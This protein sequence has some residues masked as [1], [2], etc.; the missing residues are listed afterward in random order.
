MEDLGTSGAKNWLGAILRHHPLG[1]DA[2]GEGWELEET[3][4]SAL[5]LESDMTGLLNT[6]THSGLAAEP[7]GQTVEWGKC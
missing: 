6:H 7:G 2:Q 1:T 4:R 5:N 3:G